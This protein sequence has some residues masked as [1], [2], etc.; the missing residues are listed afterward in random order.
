MKRLSIIIP[1]YNESRN[2]PLLLNRCKEVVNKDN[3]IEIVLVDNGSTDDTS[4]VLDKQATNLN[5][6]TK[7]FIYNIYSPNIFINIIT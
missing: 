1:C 5:F 2:L 7:L 6:I 3:N 4:L